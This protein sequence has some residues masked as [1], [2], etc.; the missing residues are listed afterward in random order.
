MVLMEDSRDKLSLVL[1][2]EPEGFSNILE[3]SDILEAS[4]VREVS[5]ARKRALLVS[6]RCW[7]RFFSKGALLFSSLIIKCVIYIN[8]PDR[9]NVNFN[10][11]LRPILTFGQL[12]KVRSM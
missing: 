2:R 9:W 11:L 8:T 1:D 3:C 4:H 6:L 5:D 7:E 10:E 12:S